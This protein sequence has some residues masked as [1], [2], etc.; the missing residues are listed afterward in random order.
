MKQTTALKVLLTFDILEIVVSFLGSNDIETLLAICP[1]MLAVSQENS[2]YVHKWLIRALIE[3]LRIPINPCFEQTDRR[4][5]YTGLRQLKHHFASHP[6]APVADYLCFM[7]ERKNACDILFERLIETV[8]AGKYD[9]NNTT[10][11]TQRTT[12]TL[13]PLRFLITPADLVYI[14]VHGNL[15]ITKLTLQN[16]NI[17]PDITI[18]VVSQLLSNQRLNFVSDLSK[19]ELLIDQFLAKACFPTLSREHQ[20]SFNQ[21]LFVLIKG[22][23][24]NT[25]ERILRRVVKYRRY[26]L[27]Y[28]LLINKCLQ[29]DNVQALMLFTQHMS[30]YSTSSKLMVDPRMVG[31]MMEHGR[32]NSLKYVIEHL[33][34]DAINMNAYMNNICSGI[35][36][37]VKTETCLLQSVVGYFSDTNL[38][39]LNQYLTIAG[40]DP[41]QK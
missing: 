24:N 19:V 5:V 6:E 8:Y 23:H 34:G 28:Q 36:R 3:E 33:L 35:A 26:Q 14:L 1:S 15:T 12:K 31:Q 11:L 4:L 25:I 22:F 40:S 16:I 17:A 20:F 18:N 21:V 39:L 38:E 7:V 37:S 32:V 2:Y 27:Q 10:R 13:K 30:M 29:H 9:T 41:L